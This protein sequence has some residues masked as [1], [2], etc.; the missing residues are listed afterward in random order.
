MITPDHPD[1]WNPEKFLPMLQIR[2]KSAGLQNFHL[3]DHQRLLAAAV[4]QAYA[5]QKWLVHIKPRQEGSST[6]FTGIAYQHAAFRTGCQVAIIGNKKRTAKSLAEIANRFHKSCPK[7]IRPKRHGKIQRTLEFP[8]IDSKLDVASVQ[9]DEPLRGETVQVVLGT[10]LSSWQENGGDEVWASVL[11]AVPEDGGF[12]IAESTPKHHGDQ[13][14]MLCMDA[15]K[16]DSKWMKVFIPWTMVKEYRK[17]VPPGW[18]PSKV[19]QEYW[20]EYP[21]ILPEQAYWM[22]VSGLQKCNRKIEKFKQEYPINEYD[23]WALTGDAVYDQSIIRVWL[24]D[25]D[26]G[27]GLAI[28]SDPWVQFQQPVKEDKY[29]IFCDPA[30]SWSERDHYGVVI[31]NISKCEQAAEYL[32]HMSAYQMAGKLAEWGR[33][34]NDAMI[35]VEANGVGE[36][37]LSHLVDNPNIQYRRVFHR[38]P[39]RHGRSRRKIPGW[40]SSVKTKREAEGYLQQLIE[41]E[42]VT[43]HSSR[44]LRQLLNYRG[45]WAQRSRDASGGHYDLATAWAGASWAYMNHRGSSWRQKRKNPQIVAAEAFRRLQS[46]IDGI[47]KQ[48]D[49]TRW[50]NHL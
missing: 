22:Q 19:I 41:D 42:S 29:I 18:K 32:G 33:A 27:T 30:S 17:P 14:H 47:G 10:E 12:F 3:W 6:F 1:F 40:W 45:Q 9:D 16:P 44:S 7:S 13:L 49:N 48:K 8:E 5:Q 37:V 38:S 34:Y 39:N 25:L 46:R 50:G 26:G 2:T 4:M 43:I 35:Y 20:D 21:M 23:C 24:Q 36:S 31:L 11:N 28:E 15:E